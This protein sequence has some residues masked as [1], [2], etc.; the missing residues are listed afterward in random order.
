MAHQYMPKIF[1]ESRKNTPLQ[2]P[3]PHPPIYLM[4]GPLEHGPKI[5]KS[6]SVFL[7]LYFHLCLKC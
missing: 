1:H 5:D 6:A 2:P 7:K 3:P 4:Y